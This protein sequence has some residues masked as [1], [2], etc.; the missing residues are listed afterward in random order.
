M[1][2]DGPSSSRSPGFLASAWSALA[3]EHWEADPAVPRHS[4]ARPS[5]R[6]IPAT[7]LDPFD[8]TSTHYL[9][10]AQDDAT[11]RHLTKLLTNAVDEGDEDGEEEEEE[12]DADEAGRNGTARNASPIQFATPIDPL[13]GSGLV[14]P[15][16]LSAA[17]SQQNFIF[18]DSLEDPARPAKKR[19]VEERKSA[20]KQ[21]FPEALLDDTIPKRNG[22]NI[23]EKRYRLNLNAKISALKDVVP[24]LHNM[25]SA[26]QE[27]GIASTVTEERLPGSVTPLK[28]N[29]GA[30]LEKATEYIQNLESDKQRLQAENLELRKRLQRLEERGLGTLPTPRRSFEEEAGPI[31]TQ[32]LMDP[33]LSSRIWQT[34]S[35]GSGPCIDSSCLHG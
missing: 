17:P 23:I 32:P 5:S 14:D 34:C 7:E 13:D 21:R 8:G 15:S 29:K 33:L 4:L 2:P 27:K 18:Y 9:D 22:H 6:P 1:A 19:K 26:P 35:P 31:L 10:S 28:F 25:A 20:A 30:V 24:S 3:A 12:D 11:F 16:L